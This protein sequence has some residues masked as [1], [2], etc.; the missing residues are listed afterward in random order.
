MPLTPF[1]GLSVIVHLCVIAGHKV[2]SWLPFRKPQTQSSIPRASIFSYPI[3]GIVFL[4]VM[5]NAFILVDRSV[6]DS[7]SSF[8]FINTYGAVIEKNIA[9]NIF[10]P[11]QIIPLARAQNSPSIINNTNCGLI[12]FDKWATVYNYSIINYLIS[13]NT[14]YSFSSR[15]QFANNFGIKNYTGAYGQNM[16]L[17]NDFFASSHRLD[18]LHPTLCE[19]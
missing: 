15:Q 7:H 3:I 8:R 1:I 10:Q 16:A 12:T 9:G 19:T 17:L 6:L 4:M 13:I 2:S 18:P 5:T 14:D 11:N